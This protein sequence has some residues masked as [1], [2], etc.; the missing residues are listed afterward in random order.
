MNLQVDVSGYICNNLNM[1]SIQK[2]ETGD[3][4]WG[5]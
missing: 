3:N 2:C 4:L 1:D 5:Q